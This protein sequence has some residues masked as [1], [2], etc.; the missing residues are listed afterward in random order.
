MIFS[1][2]LRNE[3]YLVITAMLAKIVE[4]KFQYYLLK[5]DYNALKKKLEEID[6][7]VSNETSKRYSI[8]IEIL[9]ESNKVAK[10]L[11]EK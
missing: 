7:L 11:A 10:L 9:N 5:S 6:G 4:K 8:E 3:R 1:T 2:I